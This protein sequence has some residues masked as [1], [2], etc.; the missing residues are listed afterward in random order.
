M[1]QTLLLLLPLLVLSGCGSSPPPAMAVSCTTRALSAR[2]V[3]VRV[4]VHNATSFA[5][6]AVVYG[7]ALSHARYVHPV[8]REEEVA[9]RVGKS[10]QPFFGWI[11]PRVPTNRPAHITFHVVKPA[12]PAAILAHELTSLPKPVQNGLAGPTYVVN[13]E[14]WDV[15]KNDQCTVG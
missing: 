5:R 6:P 11:I 2:L 10:R 4:S 13:A 15:L 1:S 7:P 8:L 9:V 14:N 3:D 12:N